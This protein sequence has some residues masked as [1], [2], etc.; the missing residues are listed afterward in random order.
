MFKKVSVTS[1][2]LSIHA[3]CHIMII[4]AIIVGE[5]W[6]FV[7]SFL[8]W[9]WI[10]AS[11]ISS[12]YHRY[13]S[14]R[15]FETGPWYEWYAQII[16]LFANPGPVL[17]WAATHRMHHAY[18]D[19]HKDPHSPTLKGFFKVYTSQWGND[20]TIERKMIK[21]LNTPCIKFFHTHYFTLIL[22]LMLVLLVMSPTL[23]LF[24]FCMPVVLAFHGYGLVNLIPHTESGKPKNSWIANILTGGEGWH[25]NHHEDSRN[26]KIGKHFWQLDPGA[27][28]IRLIK[29]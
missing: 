20:V 1:K 22:G 7:C 5:L 18:T 13:F 8:W 2:L 4:P 16:G 17:T 29:R 14:H 12:G 19:T 26:W 25:K 23:F 10:A 6:M 21:G 24:G 28:F 11:A 27:W 3:L 15:S 9:Q